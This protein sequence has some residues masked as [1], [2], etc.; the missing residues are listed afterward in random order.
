MQKVCPK[1]M[2][3]LD[4]TFFNWKIKG[5]KLQV[6]CKS[7]SRDYVRNHYN[8]NRDYYIQKAILRRM[9]LKEKGHAYLLEYLQSHPCVDCGETDIDVLEFDHT[10]RSMK[11]T[12]VSKMIH[13]GF[14][15]EKLQEEV[16]KCDIRC[17][18]CHRRKTSREENSWKSRLHDVR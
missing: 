17:A 18:N 13:I 16:E 4:Q 1:C 10:D 2:K 6:Y 7:C 11:K 9:D 14:Q 5:K 3:L 15:I 12:E 8:H